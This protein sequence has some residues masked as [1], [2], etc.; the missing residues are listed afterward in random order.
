[1]TQ[2][3]DATVKN[4]SSEKITYESTICNEKFTDVLI[5]NPFNITII[6]TN[7]TSGPQ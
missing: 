6:Y 2:A 4:P 1:M 3:V 5:I 7:I